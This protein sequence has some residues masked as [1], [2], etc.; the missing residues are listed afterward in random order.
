MLPVSKRTQ[1]EYQIDA[2]VGQQGVHHS[3]KEKEAKIEKCGFFFYLICMVLDSRRPIWMRILLV[4]IRR[5][6]QQ[7]ICIQS[8]WNPLDVLW[9]SKWLHLSVLHWIST[10]AN[11][12]NPGVTPKV[13]AIRSSGW[14]TVLGDIDWRYVNASGSHLQSQVFSIHGLTSFKLWYFLSM[15]GNVQRGLFA[16]L[17]RTTLN[18]HLPRVARSTVSAN[19]R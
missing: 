15:A 3:L 19:Q 10:L 12:L 11:G 7:G 8:P 16:H 5:W 6:P 14:V 18:W 17:Y 1:W 13:D 2:R 9:T 4:R